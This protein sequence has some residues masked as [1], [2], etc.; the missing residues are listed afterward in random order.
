MSN[1]EAAKEA[2]IAPQTLSTLWKRWQKEGEKALISR[3]RGRKAGV[4]LRL[5]RDDEIT[6]LRTV[7]KSDPVTEKLRE[8]LPHRADRLPDVRFW[9]REAV[10]ALMEL[11]VGEPLPLPTADDYLRRWGRDACCDGSIPGN[12][13]VRH[14]PNFR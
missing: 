12:S 1:G 4:G 9:N 8:R 5:K 6:I 3:K 13:S 14:M 7:I 11:R 2:G 10:R